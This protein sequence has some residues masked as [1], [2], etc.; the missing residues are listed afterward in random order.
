MNGFVKGPLEGGMGIVKGAGSLIK[1]TVG[2]A[3]NSVSKIT[4]TFSKGIGALT[5][6]FAYFN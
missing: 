1:H 6:V 5:F 4:G 3:F 2:G